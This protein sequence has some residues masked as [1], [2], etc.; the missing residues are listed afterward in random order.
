MKSTLVAFEDTDANAQRRR[1]RDSGGYYIQTLWEATQENCA[2][3][4]AR[5]GECQR[6]G[7]AWRMTNELSKGGRGPPPLL[8]PTAQWNA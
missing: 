2:I 4:G 5:Y 1:F 8:G 7:P 6:Y 3:I